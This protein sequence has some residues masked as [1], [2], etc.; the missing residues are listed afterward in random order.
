[1]Y[2]IK[3][4]LLSILCFIG[5]SGYSQKAYYVSTLAG[6]TSLL[7]S[8]PFQ[9][10]NAGYRDG[11]ASQALFN[12]PTG[13]AVD[14]LG[15][16]YV[17]DTYNNVIR[18]INVLFNTVT[19]IAGDT[20]GLAE[21]FDSNINIGYLNGTAFTAKFSNPFG[22]CVDKYGNVYVADTYNNVI[23]K[24]STSNTVTTY[25]GK[26]SLGMTFNG[27]VNGRD[28][29]AEFFNPTSI[30]IDTAGNI[31]VADNGNN[32]IRKIWAKGDSVTTLAG[33][34]P[35]TLN[36]IP[37]Y[38]N[39]AIDTA[40]FTTLFGITL[41]DNG[42]VLVSQFG[43]NA[44]AVRRLF[45]DTVTTYAGYDS[46]GFDTN[47]LNYPNPYSPLTPNIPFGYQNGKQGRG[48]ADTIV[49]IDTTLA[50][51]I[52]TPIPVG[53]LFNGPAGIGFD[54]AKNLLIADEYNNVIRLFNAKDS[55][56][57]TFA[58]SHYN[59]SVSFH[60]GWDTL[61][62]MFYNPVGVVADKNGN[63]YVS[64][65]GNNLIR[66]I[67]LQNITAVPQVKKPTATLKAYPNPCS[68]R[69]N[70]VSTFNGKADLLDVTGRV[71]WTDNSFKSP[72]TLNT[73]AISPGVYFLRV[74]S[75]S[76]TLVKKIE[77]VK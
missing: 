62:A 58:G 33:I 57:T 25:A 40:R 41:A 8:N 48:G 17:A 53:V 63:I 45:H 11:I 76:E 54:T 51:T 2:R 24:I 59:D 1:M 70:I 18:K 16:V 22:V 7:S 32:A 21:G 23:R 29:L 35:D 27:Y 61:S 26:D 56:V 74:T 13:I 4:V 71:I 47:L 3:L 36:Q 50:D 20:T 69:L 73:S 28:S 37:G 34:G 75:Q 64:D 39:G 19:T 68:G 38:I 43:N 46:I 12:A 5:I 49:T 31:Y 67:N 44:N 66:K 60:N 65:L 6:D 15:N 9:D 52:R 77:V 42:A 10:A 55:I 72:Y 30:T 14:T